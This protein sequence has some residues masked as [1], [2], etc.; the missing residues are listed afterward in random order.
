MESSNCVKIIL[1]QVHLLDELRDELNQR[2]KFVSNFPS[3]F[4]N[5]FSEQVAVVGD[6]DHRVRELRV[7]DH[8]RVPERVLVRHQDLELVMLDL[9]FDQRRL[10]SIFRDLDLNE[11]KDQ[12]TLS[13]G[14]QVNLRG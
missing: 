8:L 1:Q 7:A 11:A 13:F 10:D 5:D 6:A 3:A 9:L 14:N 4:P 12:Q 2:V